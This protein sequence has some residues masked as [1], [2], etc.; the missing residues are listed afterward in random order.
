[1]RIVSWNCRNDLNEDKIKMLA[2]IKPK[3]DILVIQECDRKFEFP[4]SFGNQDLEPKCA[5]W[6]GNIAYK[7]NNGIGVFLFDDYRFT[8]F[9]ECYPGYR[10]EFKYVL[11]FVIEKEKTSSFTLFAVWAKKYMD[12]DGGFGD[13]DTPYYY[14]QQ[15]IKAMEYYC[16]YGPSII[17]GDYNTFST[18]RN[19]R[20][21]QFEESIKPFC[22]LNNSAGE[23]KH[24]PTFFSAQYGAGTD[25]FCYATTDIDI[26]NFTIGR[27]EDFVDTNLSDHCPII[28]DFNI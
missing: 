16:I 3:P 28:V 6:Y 4:N 1:M 14:S 10:G 11:P 24:E 7:Q 19:K 2:Q 27:K 23:K 18:L 26:R 20:L 17:I 22:D 5:R 21:A 12:S 25:D 8:C 9:P 15:V 13:R